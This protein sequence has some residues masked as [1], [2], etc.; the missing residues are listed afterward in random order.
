VPRLAVVPVSTGGEQ[1]GSDA[2]P[3]FHPRSLDIHRSFECGAAAPLRSG[4]PSPFAA[5]G[6]GIFW[7]PLL[8][9]L[10]RGLRWRWVPVA[11][12]ILLLLPPAHGFPPG[13]LLGLL[14]RGCGGKRSRL[15]ITLP[16]H[17]LG[18][19]PSLTAPLAPLPISSAWPFFRSSTD[20]ASTH[21]L[22][23]LGSGQEP[24]PAA[25]LPSLSSPF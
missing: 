14:S 22:L 4:D 7:S 16:S 1:G 5:A 3:D 21:V 13:P 11:H 15:S 18:S 12:H 17:S 6:D 10:S 9:L 20:A 24:C 19:W 23:F 2:R 25:A 8:G